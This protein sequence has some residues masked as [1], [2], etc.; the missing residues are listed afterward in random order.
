MPFPEALKLSVKRRSHLMCCLCHS[1]GVEVHH[2]VPQ[3]EGGSDGEDN[4]AAL[5]PSCHETYGANPQKRKFIR[6]ARELWYDICAKRYN[7]DI[8][9]LDE[10]S[11]AVSETASKADL[12]RAVEEITATIQQAASRA[13]PLSP[14]DLPPLNVNWDQ[15]GLR[16]YLRWLYPDVTHC[17]DQ[18]LSRLF[19]DLTNVGYRSVK[20]LHSLLG[21]TREGFREFAR[22]RRDEGGMVDPG[23]D[24]Y[25]TRL[26]LAL[27]DEAYCRTHYP[28]AYAKRVGGR[29]LR[30]LSKAAV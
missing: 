19:A 25:P 18:L 3:A 9:Q 29:W 13:G 8:N 16:I 12:N 22:E 11:A 6:E 1:L 24:S 30:P 14:Y 15:A 28:N 2:I 23:T 20:E 7:S 21:I 27:F 10:L 26:F 17:G 5:C 4:A